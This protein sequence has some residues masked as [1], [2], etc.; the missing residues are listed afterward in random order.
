MNKKIGKIIAVSTLAL[1]ITSTCTAAPMAL[2]FGSK[3]AAK[4]AAKD[5]AQNIEDLVEATG[6]AYEENAESYP[7]NAKNNPN[8]PFEY[9]DTSVELGNNFL[10]G[11]FGLTRNYVNGK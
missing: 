7:D 10:S 9:V 4:S 6:D 2:G 5:Y 3:L 1:A 11:I 8:A